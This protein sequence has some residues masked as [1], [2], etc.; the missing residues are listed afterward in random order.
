M[1]IYNLN[2]LKKE[3]ERRRLLLVSLAIVIRR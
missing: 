1:N 3:I 2:E